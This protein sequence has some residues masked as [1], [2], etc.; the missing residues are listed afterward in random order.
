LQAR[1]NKK[2]AVFSAASEFNLQ[3]LGQTVSESRRFEFCMMLH[4]DSSALIGEAG[5]TGLKLAL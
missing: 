5:R 1:E 2:Y 4:S 3:R